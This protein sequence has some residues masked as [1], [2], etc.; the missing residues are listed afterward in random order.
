MNPLLT[1][2]RLGVRKVAVVLLGVGLGTMGL[3]AGIEHFAG[4]EEIK[5]LAQLI[6]VV[7]GG[8]SMFAL[9]SLAFAKVTKE[10]LRKIARTVGAL[11]MAVGATGVAFH[12]R[13]LIMMVSAD[14]S[15]LGVAMLIAPPIF[16]PGAFVL[17]GALLWVV[18]SEKLVIRIRPRLTRAHA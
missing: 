2:D 10:T 5:H 18:T 11:A 12:A 4:R 17:L 16:A 13:P 3:D 9:T 1:I 6:P 7:F 8:L 14:P 15:T